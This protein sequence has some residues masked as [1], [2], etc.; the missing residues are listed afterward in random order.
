L[1]FRLVP[2]PYEGSH[3]LDMEPDASQRQAK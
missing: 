2:G 1:C 3:L